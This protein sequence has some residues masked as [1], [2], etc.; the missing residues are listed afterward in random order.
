[1]KHN[2]RAKSNPHNNSQSHPSRL[3]IRYQAADNAKLAIL[4]QFPQIFIQANSN[5][6]SA[7]Y[8][9]INPE[10]HQENSYVDSAA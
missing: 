4:R 9:Q 6:F 8:T 7:K 3:T 1:M 10:Q 2:T 5:G